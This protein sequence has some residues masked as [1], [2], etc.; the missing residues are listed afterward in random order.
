MVY[1]PGELKKDPPQEA[2]QRVNLNKKF[3]TKT[4]LG[5]TR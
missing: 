1:E 4:I 2:E 3:M 5:E